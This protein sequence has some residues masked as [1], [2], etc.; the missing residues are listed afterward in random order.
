MARLGGGLPG[1]ADWGGQ[2]RQDVLL[3]ETWN[4]CRCSGKHEGCRNTP[5]W[6]WKT[7]RMGHRQP[8]RN[9]LFL[10]HKGLPL[11]KFRCSG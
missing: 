10:L 3:S 11:S 4:L 5:Q 9:V 8:Q 6:D 7:E 2:G 1:A